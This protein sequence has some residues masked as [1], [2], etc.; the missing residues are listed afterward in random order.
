MAILPIAEADWCNTKLPGGG[1]KTA[2]RLAFIPLARH[3]SDECQWFREKPPWRNVDDLLFRSVVVVWQMTDPC[4]IC[5]DETRPLWI[6]LTVEDSKDVQLWKRFRDYREI[7]YHV[8]Q[9]LGFPMNGG[10]NYKAWY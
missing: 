10:V 3:V 4:N 2:L 1:A 8:L 9:D 5:T 6:L 7:L